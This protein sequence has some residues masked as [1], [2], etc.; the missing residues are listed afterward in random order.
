MTSFKILLLF[1]A[2]AAAATKAAP[3]GPGGLQILHLSPQKLQALY[4][5][6]PDKGLYVV[7]KIGRERYV[8][9]ST[10]DGVEVASVWFSKSSSVL[11]KIMGHS[12]FIH[13]NAIHGGQ[14][15]MDAFVVPA[16]KTRRVKKEMKRSHFSAKLFHTLDT[17][18]MNQT[19]DAAFFEL[20]SHPSL[21]GVFKMSEA[22]GQ[23]DITGSSNPAALQFHV[24]ALHFAKLQSRPE[25]NTVSQ[26][27]EDSEKKLDEDVF[28]PRRIEKRATCTRRRWWGSTIR[29]YGCAR[30]PT[31]SNCKGL[32]GPRCTCW[33]WVCGDCCYH[34]GCYEH[35]VCCSKHGYKSIPCVFI[36]NL[37]CDSHQW[38]C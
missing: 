38:K 18:S 23:A 4:H 30:C 35:D 37:T 33:R 17:E 27:A 2:V 10:L 25:F 1:S 6:S 32:C 24:M 34:Q 16:G 13:N 11:W 20:L 5:T 21:K 29:E 31:G 8:T 19:M 36:L 12:F 14:A 9:V 26:P 7:S 3:S 15:R 22:L 28:L